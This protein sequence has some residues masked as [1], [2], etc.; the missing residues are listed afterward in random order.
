MISFYWVNIIAFII[1]AMSS[2]I[3]KKTHEK[4]LHNMSKD[5]QWLPLNDGAEGAVVT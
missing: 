2:V 5:L 1:Y 4:I 3:Y